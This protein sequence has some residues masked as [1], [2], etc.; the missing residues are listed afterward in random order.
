[1]LFMGIRSAATRGD[2]TSGKFCHE[3]SDPSLQYS[4]YSGMRE[5]IDAHRLL[6]SSPMDLWQEI[7]VHQTSSQPAS[8][9]KAGQR[10]RT[11]HQSHQA[12]GRGTQRPAAMSATA[13]SRIALLWSRCRSSYSMAVR[14]RLKRFS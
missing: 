7:V 6:L 2:E 13:A 8:N 5:L 10:S 4:S 11:A 1:M 3:L 14:C 9:W 12:P